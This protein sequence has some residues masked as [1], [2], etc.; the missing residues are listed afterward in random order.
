MLSLFAV[1]AFSS[2]KVVEGEGPSPYERR[3]INP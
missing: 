1:G 3:A 2:T